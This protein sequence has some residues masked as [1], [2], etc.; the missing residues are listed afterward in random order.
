MGI[1]VDEYR[2]KLLDWQC[3]TADDLIA[4]VRSAVPDADLAVKWSRLVFT[5]V[6][7]FCYIKP[8]KA[9]MSIGFWWGARIDDPD[10]VLEGD[11]EKMRHVTFREG[12]RVDREL[13]AP[14]VQA[15]NRLNFELGDP[16][17]TRL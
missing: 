16:T 3:A 6:G 1:P 15:A 13:L 10:G 8:A 7:P 11:G 12:D 17:R 9:H 5:T 2:A 14:L 4:L